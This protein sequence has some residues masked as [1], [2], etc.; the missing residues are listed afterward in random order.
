MEGES[1]SKAGPLTSAHLALNSREEDLRRNAIVPRE[2]G[3][4]MVD[5]GQSPL[6]RLREQRTRGIEKA[7]A[8]TGT[9]RLAPGQRTNLSEAHALE[10]ERSSF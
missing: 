10:G 9:T 7:P 1:C 2:Y 5:E 3:A 6:A 4:S 8:P